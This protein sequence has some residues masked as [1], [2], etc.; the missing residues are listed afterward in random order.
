MDVDNR[1]ITNRQINNDCTSF[2]VTGITGS[3]ECWNV[4]DVTGQ[5]GFFSLR[6]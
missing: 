1:Q 4:G 2:V 5:S 3:I 6:N